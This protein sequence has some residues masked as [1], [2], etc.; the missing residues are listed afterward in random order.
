MAVIGYDEV[1]ET[2]SVQLADRNGVR[3]DSDSWHSTGI[4]NDLA[5]GGRHAERE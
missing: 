1:V 4:E 5:G 3:L 2:G